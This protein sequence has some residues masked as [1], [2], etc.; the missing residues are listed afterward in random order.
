MFT[1][2]GYAVGGEVDYAL[3]SPQ[4]IGYYLYTP[5]ERPVHPIHADQDQMDCHQ[6]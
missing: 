3:Q 5:M 1:S 6:S 2:G 4:A